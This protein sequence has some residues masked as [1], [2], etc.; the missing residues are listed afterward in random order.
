[1]SDTTNSYQQLYEPIVTEKPK[2]KKVSI[3]LNILLF[4]TTFVATTQAGVLWLG[5]DPYDIT[6]FS[7]GL[8]Y[9]ITILL[10]L[11]FHEF[12]HYFAARFHKVEVTLPFYIPFPI[13]TISF[14]T[15]G[16][17]IRM[18]EQVKSRKALFDIG[19]AGPIAGFIVTL[20]IL[21]YGLINLPPVE[22]LYQIHPDYAFNGIPVKGEFM[23]SDTLLYILL[24]KIFVLH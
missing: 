22:Y 3:W 21:I 15:M 4:I 6:N 1:L 2:K 13:F 8:P 24:V 5:R 20:A 18:R 12:G 9:S 7:I 11:T 10:I 14:G 19:I 17:V 16:A 23:F